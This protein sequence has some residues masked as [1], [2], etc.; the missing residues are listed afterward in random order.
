M[1]K[2]ITP[3]GLAALYLVGGA[4]AAALGTTPL[5]AWLDTQDNETLRDLAPKVQ[6]F[7]V[8][9]GLDRPY[10]FLH[11]VVRDAEAAKFIGSR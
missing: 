2:G 9:S 4:V 11:Q 7:G 1:A 6:A 3:I 10:Q 8:G 5:A